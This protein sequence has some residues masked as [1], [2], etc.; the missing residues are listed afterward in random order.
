MTVFRSGLRL[1]VLGIVLGLPPSVVAV[2]PPGA[3]PQSSPIDNL[4]VRQHRRSYYPSIGAPMP[5]PTRLG[6]I[7]DT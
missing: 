6:L 4:Q 7:L 2:V 5:D 1:S 3:R